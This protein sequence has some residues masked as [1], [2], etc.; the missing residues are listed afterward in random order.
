MILSNDALSIVFSSLYVNDIVKCRLVNKQFKYA[1]DNKYVWTN[2]LNID[3]PNIVPKIKAD[4]NFGKY[5][6][7]HDMNQFTEKHEIANGVDS[8]INAQR[9]R[10]VCHNLKLIP[11]WIGQLISLQRLVLFSNQLTSLPSEFGQ[12]VNLQTVFLDKT[13]TNIPSKVKHIIKEHK[14]HL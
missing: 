9:L 14:H 13:V 5:K 10:K 6:I 2:L 12:L 4:N 3:Y 1:I 8:L 11:K 7:C